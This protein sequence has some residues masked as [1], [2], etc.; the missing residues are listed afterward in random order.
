MKKNVIYFQNR[1][2]TR[3]E[4][5]A[6][7]AKLT[8]E[9]LEQK[10][11]T[12][13]PELTDRLAREHAYITGDSELLQR[14]VLFQDLFRYAGER[15][16]FVQSGPE[17]LESLTAYCLGLT[18]VDPM[19]MEIPVESFV[20]DQYPRLLVPQDGVQELTAYLADT[21]PGV[22]PD[23]V[24]TVDDFATH[25]DITLRAIGAFTG[26]RPDLYSLDF[27]DPDVYAALGDDRFSPVLSSSIQEKIHPQT[28]EELMAAYFFSKLESTGL[29]HKYL[30]PL[31]D[32]YLAAPKEPEGNSGPASL[33]I[34]R[35]CRL[36]DDQ[37]VA[38]LAEEGGCS[39]E[40]LMRAARKLNSRASIQIFDDLA[41]KIFSACRRLGIPFRVSAPVL[42]HIFP[43]SLYIFCDFLAVSTAGIL[44]AAIQF[45]W[46]VYIKVN[47]AGSLLSKIGSES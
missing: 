26:T 20:T 11:P 27:S 17:L 2:L 10:F 40:R 47:Y 43:L 28:L 46:A 6:L 29:P 35:G 31:L 12:V 34:S 41:D 36:Y 4:A 45:Y 39:L 8:Q 16:C 37:R 33:K 38:H 13:T 14:F 21:C 19:R 15:Q 7:L 1:T 9:G 30:D 22:D 25:Y 3:S 42:T 32:Q 5:S 24:M 44:F 18:P 23:S